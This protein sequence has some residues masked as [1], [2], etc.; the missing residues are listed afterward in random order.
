MFIFSKD[1]IDHETLYPCSPSVPDIT[2]SCWSFARNETAEETCIV[3]LEPCED[4]ISDQSNANDSNDQSEATDQSEL[5]TNCVKIIDNI[6][7]EDLKFNDGSPV[8]C[9]DQ[10]SYFLIGLSIDERKT[11]TL[12]LQNVPGDLMNTISQHYK[13]GEPEM[14][15]KNLQIDY[16][17]TEFQEPEIL[18]DLSEKN[19]CYD[20]ENSD[21]RTSNSEND[22]KG[23]NG[24]IGC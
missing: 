19:G 1:K 6:E 4:G 5:K 12:I 23:S 9:K 8:I 22:A 7:I 15:S 11:D 13:T 20:D 24:N 3:Q 14:D 17:G 21:D 18:P 16:E 2:S 10:I